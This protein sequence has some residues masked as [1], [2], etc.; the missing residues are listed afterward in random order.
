MQLGKRPAFA[1]ISLA[2]CLPLGVAH[3]TTMSYSTYPAW[4]QNVTSP[5]ELNF[6]AI[7]TSGNYSN[8]TG[9]SLVPMSGTAYP[10][11]F[12]GPTGSGYQLSG[13][14]YG[15]HSYTSLFGPSGGL[16]DIQINLPGS[17]ENALLIGLG[18]TGAASSLTVALSDGETFSVAA[19]PNAVEFLGLSISHD[20][21]SLTVSAASQ[22]VINDF[23]FANSKLA[24]DSNQNPPQSP[25]IEGSTLSLIGGG[26]L[27]LFGARRR[28][29]SNKLA[30]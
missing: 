8:S 27:S 9:K 7:S 18:S 21:T 28:L 16:G 20:I 23:Y 24:Q 17:G 13:G 14:A 19:S 29:L 5:I 6:T 1:L 12:T 22:P 26:L 3:A 2:L 30:S 25:A 15:S 4:S 11:I 10:F